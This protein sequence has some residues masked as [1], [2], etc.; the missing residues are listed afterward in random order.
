MECCRETDR[1]TDMH[2]YVWF[3]L[4]LRNLQIEKYAVCVVYKS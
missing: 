4:Y 2:A 1:Q 3:L